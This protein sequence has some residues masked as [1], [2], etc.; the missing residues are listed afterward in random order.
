MEVSRNQDDWA[1]V[2]TPRTKEVAR[3]ANHRST[4]RSLVRGLMTVTAIQNPSQA[5]RSASGRPCV[6]G[7]DSIGG[8]YHEVSMGSTPKPIK[9]VYAGGGVL[10]HCLGTGSTLSADSVAW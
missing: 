3:C 7:I 5:G 8:T 1:K 6:L 10:A 9:N 2:A 4:M